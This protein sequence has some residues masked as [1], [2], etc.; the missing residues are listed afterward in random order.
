MK[1]PYLFIDHDQFGVKAVIIDETN[2][3]KTVL[4]SCEI[5]FKDLPEKGQDRSD[6]ALFN[7]A[8]DSVAETMDINSCPNAV[9]L[10]SPAVVHFRTISLP[11][12]SEKKIQQT[13]PFELEPLLPLN[14]ETYISHF[15]ILDQQAD[16]SMILTASIAESRVESYFLKLAGFGIRPKMITP[17]G[18]SAVVAFLK[19]HP[20]LNDFIWLDITENRIIL[21]LIHNRKPWVL[22]TL[23]GSFLVSEKLAGCLCQT[24]TGFY[25]KT[26]EDIE[27]DLITGF[28]RDFPDR[29]NFLN[30]LEKAVVE[31]ADQGSRY[32][33]IPKDQRVQGIDGDK[34]L[35]AVSPDDTTDTLINFCKG[36]YSSVS[37]LKTHF[38]PIAAGIVL[39][40]FTLGMGLFSTGLDNSNLYKK[41]N[42]LDETALSIFMKTFPDQKRIQDPYLQMKANIQEIMKKAGSD[43][44]K[45]LIAGKEVKAM[46]I[47]KELSMKIVP[48]ID[49]EISSFLL[50]AGR[51][52]LSGS[53]DNFN[54][55]DKIKTSLESSEYFKKVNISSAATD[56]KGDRVNF[57]FNIDL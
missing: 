34:W 3:E 53:T 45:P 23:P 9:I 36:K 22:R 35:T 12:H 51:I 37:F 4:N 1:G 29:D 19:A 27:F 2:Q 20:Q 38:Y 28:D 15:H 17:A 16:L 25:Q 46:D 7:T 10:I 21:I 56:K 24:V 41:I 6:T 40:F 18:Y 42:F 50:N 31:R 39:F 26:G 32:L 13:L 30:T 49:V 52:V 54:N 11:F 33:N 14:N 48:A 5:L 8:M 44:D 47:L 55:V 43:T 57:K